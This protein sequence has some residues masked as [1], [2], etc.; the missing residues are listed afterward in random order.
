ME[1]VPN[2]VGVDG[3]KS[4]WIAVWWA[5]TALKFFVYD[6]A[7]ALVDAHRQDRVIAVD[8]PIGLPERNGRS[9]D[10]EARRFVGGRRASSVFSVPVRGILDA[11]SQPEAS[12]RH[13]EIDGR[14]FGA[15]SFAILPK[16][17]EWDELLQSDTQ[18]RAVL[19]E[20]H[21]EVSFAALNGGVGKGL[22]F[23]KKS[24]DGANVRTALL[25][26]VFG[27][28]NVTGLVRS[29]ARRQAA[30][31]DV[32]D[33]LVALWSAE[34]IATGKSVCLPTPP[35]SDSTGLTTAISY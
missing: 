11:T 21:P 8:I 5:N 14:G 18:L 35:D 32:L 6:S 33:A 15:Q 9:A 34:R 23:N 30:T 29:V 25:S 2:C 16:I 22:A 4:G 28:E 20:I 3:A 17:R 27:F 26:T 24:R 19:R 7:R 31:D 13:R 12:R 1:R 10:N